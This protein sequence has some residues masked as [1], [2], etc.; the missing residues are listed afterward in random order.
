MIKVKIPS[1]LHS[2]TN[3]K[4]LVQA[5]GESLEELLDDLDR[6]FRGI[7]FRIVNEQDQIRPH[8]KIFIGKRQTFDLATSISDSDEVT[9]VQAFSGG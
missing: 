6:Q 8:I 5:R 2:Y 4:S 9:L 1:P 7:R 3:S